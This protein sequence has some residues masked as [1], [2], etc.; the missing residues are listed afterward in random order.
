MAVV[1]VVVLVL[2]LC[3]LPLTIASFKKG[4]TDTLRGI[5]VILRSSWSVVGCG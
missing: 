4:T 1:C 5:G 2:G 3:P